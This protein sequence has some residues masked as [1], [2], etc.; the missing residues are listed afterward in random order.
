MFKFGL[1]TAIG[2]IIVKSGT[3]IIPQ[4]LLGIAIV[5][6][7]G[8]IFALMTQ[9]HGHPPEPNTQPLIYRR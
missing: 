3:Q 7:G 1:R 5:V 9:G 4:P 8:L 6:G 2:S